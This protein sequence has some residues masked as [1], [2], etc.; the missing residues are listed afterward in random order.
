VSV[1]DV[2]KSYSGGRGR[3]LDHLS[4]HVDDG[5]LVVLEGPSGSGKSTTLHLVAA[6]DRVDSGIIR[7]RGRDLARR[8]GLARYRR[9]QVGMIFQLHN[10]LPHLD[11]VQNVEVVM[12]GSRLRRAARR[13]RAR[14]LL[15]AVGLDTQAR[16]CPPELSGGERQR[17]AVARALAN[18]PPVLLADEPT[19]SLDD[20]TAALVIGLLRDH[21]AAGGAV[22]AVSHDP[23]LTDAADRVLRLEA[24]RITTSE[25]RRDGQPESGNDEQRPVEVV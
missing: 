3:V 17:I 18:D 20:A 15:H 23:R 13:A 6:L 8:R 9:E 19:G 10:L 1:A 21:C 16:V 11:A 4:F 5:E 25:A 7:V 14:T 22:L 2:V 24:G 12:F